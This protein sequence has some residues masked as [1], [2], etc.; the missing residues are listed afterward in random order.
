MG[1]FSSEPK[2]NNAKVWGSKAFVKSNKDIYALSV[3]QWSKICSSI[4]PDQLSK[5]D[6][7]L[8]R[9]LN[10]QGIIKL[11]K[12]NELELGDKEIYKVFEKALNQLIV[13]YAFRTLE[14]GYDDFTK[15]NAI[16]KDDFIDQIGDIFDLSE[17]NK[18]EIKEYIVKYGSTVTSKYFN[19]KELTPELSQEFS[20]LKQKEIK[21]LILKIYTSTGLINFIE[22]PTPEEMN[23]I[24]TDL[25]MDIIVFNSFL[26]NATLIS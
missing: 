8:G 5:I 25:Q 14:I 16:T 15:T 17:D 26:K 21:W 3:R 2:Y 20:E 13:Y 19:A 10:D 22:F 6:Q 4:L 9:I 18:K 11:V 12:K 1:L 24:K 7:N 23:N